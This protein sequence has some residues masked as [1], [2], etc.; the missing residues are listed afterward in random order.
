MDDELESLR[1]KLLNVKIESSKTKIAAIDEALKS[2]TIKKK[3][4]LILL[5]IRAREFEELSKNE[6]ERDYQQGGQPCR[7]N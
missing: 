7:K 2:G 4:D 5:D 6:F 1:S 3:L